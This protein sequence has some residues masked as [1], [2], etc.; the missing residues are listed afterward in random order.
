MLIARVIVDVS[1]RSLDRAFDYLVPSQLEA[2]EVG[3]AV[4]VEF[5][6]RP[7]VAYVIELVEKEK[8]DYKLKPL[9]G[10]LSSPYFDAKA[11]ELAFWI[12]R[13]YMSPLVHAFNLFTPPG[14][15]P[16]MKHINDSWELVYPGVGPVDDRWVFLEKDAQ[17]FVPKKNAYK[18]QRVIDVL[19]C[20]GMRVSELS[21]ELGN[22]TSTLKSL[23]QK[24]VVHIEHRRRIRALAKTSFADGNNNITL[25]DE[26]QKAIQVIENSFD[27]K[28]P[29]VL[30]GVTG[31]GK[32]EVYL[33]VIA[34]I[35][36]KGKSACVL[37]PEIS[38][39]PQTVGRF[40][41]R[42]GDE[43]AVLHS[44]LSLGER[45][46][47]WDLV[48]QGLARVVVGTRSALFAPLKNLGLIIIDEEHEQ[49]YKQESSPRYHAR[50]VAIKMGELYG[51]S[52]VLGS[53]TPSITTL[54]HCSKKM[55]PYNSWIR[56]TLT[57]RPNKQQLP[58]VKIIDMAQEFSDGS[59]SMFASE[60]KDALKTTYENKEKAVLLLNKRGFASFVLCR[61]CG[62]VPQCPHCSVSLTFHEI[63]N[64]L[65]CHHCGYEQRSITVCP[66]CGSPYLRKFGTG[67]QRVEEE[68]RSILPQDFPV[69]RM[70]A[71]TTKGKGK[72][73]KLLEEFGSAESAVLL[74]TQM[75][76]KGLDFPD[77]TLVGVINADTTLNMPDYMASERTYQLLEQ[78]SG[79]AGRAQKAG[80]VL[81]QT[82]Q[83]QSLAVKAAA[84]HNRSIL[85][86]EDLP[87]RKALHYPPY[88]RLANVL[89]WGKDE[90]K[91]KTCATQ[92]H[93]AISS[94]LVSAHKAWE[95][96]PVTPCI[97]ERLKGNYR[98]HI[99]IKAPLD[100]NFFE[101]LH[102]ILAKQHKQ[103]D[104][105]TAV[106]VDPSSLL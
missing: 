104:I 49:T 12:A 29:V 35:L 65:V 46:D 66:E 67:T 4:S 50:D 52:V 47:Q 5:G 72:H 59:R 21:L 1:A 97:F 41:S 99:L 84:F 31:C 22:V 45:F 82:Y 14:G 102:P 27:S 73:E 92:L 61:E 77:V 79:R 70:D 94:A 17:N 8:S 86:D 76:A 3:C 74:G 100:T 78:V 6:A 56:V 51:A 16:H 90:Q 20:G 25:T 42:F 64:K 32:T 9:L 75:V 91:V 103:R 57:K 53:A 24:G 88:V 71:D 69:I 55:F 83:A 95:L 43:V 40:R 39:T 89:V 63:G 2:V 80:R 68:L 38:L 105:Y 87:M 37:V 81:I 15:H 54:S 36:K 34:H 62:H 13:E 11:A 101:I 19:A 60:L 18:Q 48:H 58:Q 23:E 7:V 30:D 28:V 85:L 10:I 96:L 33:Q 93:L 106:D 98:W 26:Q 44:R